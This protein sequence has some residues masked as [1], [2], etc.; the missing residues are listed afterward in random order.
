MPIIDDQTRVTDRRPGARWAWVLVVAGLAVLWVLLATALSF[1]SHATPPG[2]PKALIQKMNS[3]ILSTAEASRGYGDWTTAAQSIQQVNADAELSVSDKHRY[4]R[5]GAEANANIG[6]SARAAAFYERFLSMGVGLKA[7]GC[8]S[9][10]GGPASISPT[11][12]TDMLH[13]PLG[14]GYAAALK[15]AGTLDTTRIRLVKALKKSPSDARLNLLLF[16][17]EQAEGH[18]E[19]ARERAAQV[20]AL[21]APR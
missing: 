4:F 10:H 18:T 17:I 19:A 2:N 12:L 13:T 15:R 9:C 3:D 5:I 11:R 8:Q 1:V 14:T 20:K 16:Y 21:D 7:A 6:Q